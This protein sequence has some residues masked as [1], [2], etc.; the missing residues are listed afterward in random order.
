MT[1]IEKLNPSKFEDIKFHYVVQN[2]QKG[3]GHAISLAEHLIQDEPFAV[4]LPDDLF[5]S[6]DSCL[7]Q[8]KR[9]YEISNASVIAVN[10]I[11]LEDIHKYGVIKPGNIKIT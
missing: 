8:L 1:Y 6:N 5:F 7:N 2:E 9:S 10:E 3:L 4:L 11:E